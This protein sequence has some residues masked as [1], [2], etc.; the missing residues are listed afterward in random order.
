MKI[1]KIGYLVLVLSLLQSSIALC[2][3]SDEKWD[4]MLIREDKV[5]PS[6]TDEYEMTLVDLKEFLTRK[7]VTEFNYFTHMQDDYFFTHVTPI[8]HLKDLGKGIHSL[9]AYAVKD[10][11]LDLIFSYLNEAIE[12]YR[13]YIVQYRPEFSYIPEGDNWGTG[14]PYRK[15]SY[16][17]FQP[18]TETEV[19]AVLSAWKKLYENKGIQ[20]GFR[21]FSGF[22]GVEQPLY[23]LTT[24]AEDP[25]DYHEKLQTTSG[26]LGEEGAELWEKMLGYV[27]QVTAVEGWFL[28]KY[29]YAP[30]LRM[31]E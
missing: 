21:V 5:Y 20:S 25:L 18:G 26:I 14:S 17:Y 27:S 2:Q 16:Y 19:E 13:Y 31:A 22:I 29:S 30:G 15:W 1:N 3:L 24:W 11:E 6:M 28:P 8:D 4:L 23:I 12:F 7:N 10:P 9:M